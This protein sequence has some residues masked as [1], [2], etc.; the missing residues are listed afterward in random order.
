MKTFNL[1]TGEN[2]WH[3]RASLSEKLSVSYICTGENFGIAQY[4]P[5]GRECRSALRV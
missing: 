5:T 2:A 4:A 1:V 3:F